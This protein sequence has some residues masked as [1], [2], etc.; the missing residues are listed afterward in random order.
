MGDEAERV[1]ATL[2]RRS[3]QVLAIAAAN[4]PTTLV[5]GAW[6]C[7]AFGGDPRLVADAFGAALDAGFARAFRRVVFAV[8]VRRR[9]DESN[10][11]AFRARFA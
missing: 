7:G 1:P 3:A 4:A 9:P 11:L 8:L 5:L 2:R 10:L 6:G